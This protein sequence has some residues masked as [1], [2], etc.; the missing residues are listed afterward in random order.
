MVVDVISASKY[1]SKTVALNA[2]INTHME[3]KKLLLSADKCSSIHIGNKTNKADCA[4]VKVHNY[5][6]K[7]SENEYTF[8][9]L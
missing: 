7:N 1:G 8:K 5:E 3:R 4:S 6:M 9:I 2:C